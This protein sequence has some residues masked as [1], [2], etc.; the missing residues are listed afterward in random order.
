MTAFRSD[1]Q[2]IRPA[3]KWENV[4][5]NQEAELKSGWETTMIVNWD[6][7]ITELAFK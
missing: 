3:S 5:E 2:Y 6:V 1:I 7:Q 4:K